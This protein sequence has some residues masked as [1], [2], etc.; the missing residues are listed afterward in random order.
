MHNAHIGFFAPELGFL[1]YCISVF[2]SRQNDDTEATGRQL[3]FIPLKKHCGDMSYQKYFV[4][5]SVLHM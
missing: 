3:N 1:Y 4:Q 2:H 5:R